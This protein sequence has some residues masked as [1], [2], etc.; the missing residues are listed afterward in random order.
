MFILVNKKDP[1][2]KAQT[3]NVGLKDWYLRHGYEEASRTAG[4]ASSGDQSKVFIDGAPYTGG[5][6]VMK[7]KSKRAVDDDEQ[8]PA[9]LSALAD[10][11]SKGEGD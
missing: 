2:L 3:A 1:N 9:D 4:V 6:I 10:D 7:P 8:P 5:T 11:L